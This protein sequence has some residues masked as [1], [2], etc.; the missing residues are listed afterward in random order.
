[1]L[2]IGVPKRPAPQSVLGTVVQ[3]SQGR[4]SI[5]H[6]VQ[7]GAVGQ[8]GHAGSRIGESGIGEQTF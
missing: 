6:S 3:T 2:G 8:T 1:M 7:I 4:A 5:G